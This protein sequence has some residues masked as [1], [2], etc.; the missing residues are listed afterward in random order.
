M[1]VEVSVWLSNLSKTTQRVHVEP[2]NIISQTFICIGI[3][4]ASIKRQIL[5]QEVQSGA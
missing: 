2:L 4:W 5:T 3:T 1:P